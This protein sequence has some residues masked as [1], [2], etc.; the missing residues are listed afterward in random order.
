[1]NSFDAKIGEIR[2][3][4]YDFIRGGILLSLDRMNKV[5]INPS[6]L[7]RAQEGQPLSFDINSSIIFY[8]IFSLGGSYR[9]GDSF[10]SFIDLKISER[11][12]FGYSYDWTS[13]NLNAF[14]NGTHEFMINYRSILRG[15]H[16]D[17]DCPQYYQYR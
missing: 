9:L 3:A 16:K 8:D 5:K 17:P 15:I 11:L 1:M 13:S 7:V 10:I 6:I 14:S 2:E 12:H 4:R